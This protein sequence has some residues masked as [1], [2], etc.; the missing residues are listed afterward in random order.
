MDYE[1]S[2]EY[3]DFLIV[4]A[5]TLWIK[6]EKQIL[7]KRYP[8][9][10]IT[11]KIYYQYFNHLKR[12]SNQ[13]SKNSIKSTPIHFVFTR[14]PSLFFIHV[15]SR[16]ILLESS[17]STFLYTHT[18]IYIRISVRMHD[19]EL[20]KS[21]SASRHECVPRRHRKMYSDTMTFFLREQIFN[22]PYTPA[23]VAPLLFLLYER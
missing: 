21:R 20:I 18:Y 3:I 23:L 19:R 12:K 22:F 4:F 14:S 16:R 5:V 6:K 11:L 15:A 2:R 8:L 9:F 7:E 17:D 13:R 10:H 1:E